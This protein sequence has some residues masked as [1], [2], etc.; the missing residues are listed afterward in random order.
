MKVSQD[1]I[2][3]IVLR[4]E[5]VKLYTEKMNHGIVLTHV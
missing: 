2:S 5:S 4:V 3:Y 1:D